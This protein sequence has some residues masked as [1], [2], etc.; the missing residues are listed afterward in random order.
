MF[1]IQLRLYLEA[2]GCGT[3]IQLALSATD[4]HSAN[5]ILHI[6]FQV[7]T[8][9]ETADACWQLKPESEMGW[10]PHNQPCAG[11]LGLS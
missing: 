4:R 1:D 2:A 10:S 8:T 9:F 6:Y 11:V 3:S 5:Y 7:L